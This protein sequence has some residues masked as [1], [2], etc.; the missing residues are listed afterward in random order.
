M[1]AA[2][3]Q[4]GAESAPVPASAILVKGAWPSY[5][6]S[7]SALPEG[8]VISQNRYDNA[9][10]G[11]SYTFSDGWTQR[12]EGPPPSDSGYYVL[13]QIEP[14][15]V[16]NAQRG[17][18]LIAA[19]DLFFTT[20]SARNAAEFIDQFRN[21][22]AEDYRVERTG[23]VRMTGYE[24]ERLDYLSPA[25]G[26]HWRVLA[27]EI[28]CHVLEFVFTGS[29]TRSLDR[30][31]A[32]LGELIQRADSAPVCIKDF[33]SYDTVLEREEP[34]FSEQRFNQVPVRIVIGRDGKVKHVHFL[35]AFP[36]QARAI[37]EALEQWRFKPYS[38]NGQAVE[39][40]TGIVFGRAPRSSISTL[41]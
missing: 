22:L 35:S 7:P 39:V 40:E 18:F 34:V 6:G 32:S 25:S 10:F 11:V 12:Y 21:R 38:V 27:T 41:H 19:Q 23:K 16:R 30:Q 36:E 26:L 29:D 9:Y 15:E 2:S 13:A 31:I 1:F 8:G 4:G 17:H 24:F 3:A 20:A 14:L 28:R 37:T 33:A 5:T